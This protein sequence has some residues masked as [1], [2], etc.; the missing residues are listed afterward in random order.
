[1]G[2]NH[3][4]RFVR[5]WSMNLKRLGLVLAMTLTAT[6]CSASEQFA[7][8]S[9]AE[10]VVFV[11]QAASVSQVWQSLDD[12]QFRIA[13]NC[14]DVSVRGTPVDGQFVPVDASH[15]STCPP[16]DEL[17]VFDEPF[18]I[19]RT[20][21]GLAVTL[22][23]EVFTFDAPAII[24]LD[25]VFSDEWFLVAQSGVE[26]DLG[27]VWLRIDR[28]RIEGRGNCGAFE[29]SIAVEG[30][31]IST[32]DVR[33][34]SACAGLEL[35]FDLLAG[36]DL[37]ALGSD[38]GPSIWAG[39]DRWLALEPADVPMVPLG[40]LDATFV[41]QE[42]FV[43]GEFHATEY[44][45]GDEV[46]ATLPDYPFR[47]ELTASEASWFSDCNQTYGS[48]LWTGTGVETSSVSQTAMELS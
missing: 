2:G 39:P 13:S 37:V 6:A 36:R 22:D 43:L 30:S 44:R 40:E 26:R 16:G 33:Y 32:G 38:L 8:A 21:T 7:E 24:P 34:Q 4:P 11:R 1:M 31:T 3:I 35:I 20:D 25:P 9:E 46:R 27:A 14:G 17:P 12:R 42:P 18:T 28:D 19:A 41:R 23:D 47:L 15:Y 5:P 10:P 29:T 45:V 48:V